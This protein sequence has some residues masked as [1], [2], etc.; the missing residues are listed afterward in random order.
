MGA[1]TGIGAA[2]DVLKG[3]WK[4]VL[5]VGVVAALG[6]A[7][8]LTRG[9]LAS[10]THERD[11]AR[12]SLAVERA[13]HAVTRQSVNTLQSALAMKNRESE[14]R[15]KAFEAARARDAKDVAAADARYLAAE[16]RRKALEAFARDSG[17]ACPVPD[18]LLSAIEGL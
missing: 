3:N 10:R 8:M 16:G 14:E 4:L 9:T 5:T 17:K 18:G 11:A 6:I 1:L 12:A 7:L 15:A 13:N 2:F